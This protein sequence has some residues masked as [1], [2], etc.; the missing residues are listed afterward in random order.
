MTTVDNKDTAIAL[1]FLG[2][3][4][5]GWN[6]SVCLANS[7]ICL[8]DQREIGIA[9]GL[10]ASMRSAICAVLVAVYTSILTNRLTETTSTGIPP[11]LIE[12]GLPAES[13]ADF[14]GVVSTAGTTAPASVYSGVQ[15]ITDKIVEVGVRAYQVANVEAF[16]TVYFS[17]IAFSAISIIMTI[18]APNTEKWMTG[19]VAATLNQ[20]ETTSD[21]EK[22]VRH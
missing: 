8:D 12:A 17:T 7:T 22:A 18:W 4:W 19:N 10:A 6:E 5:I 3:F 11:K 13:I 2:C 1:I 15:G 14:L 20:E 9:G 21:E 16:R